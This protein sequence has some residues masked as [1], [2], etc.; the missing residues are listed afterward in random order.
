MHCS[1]YCDLMVLTH[2]KSAVVSVVPMG[3]FGT[4]FITEASIKKEGTKKKARAEYRAGKMDFLEEVLQ[5]PNLYGWE[6]TKSSICI[7]WEG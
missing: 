3:P 2:T 5:N 4:S 7:V 1:F 6:K